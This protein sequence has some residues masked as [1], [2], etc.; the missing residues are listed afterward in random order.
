MKMID[1][2]RFKYLSS[3]YKIIISGKVNVFGSDYNQLS[4]IVS[5]DYCLII[6]INDA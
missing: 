3:V 5:Q 2:S 1:Y 6:Y 4:E